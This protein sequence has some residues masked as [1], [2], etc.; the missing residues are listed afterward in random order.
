MS[1]LRATV[2]LLSAGAI[3]GAGYYYGSERTRRNLEV[4]KLVGVHYTQMGEYQTLKEKLDAALDVPGAVLD[5][6]KEDIATVRGHMQTYLDNID[7][8]NST[9][10]LHDT[11][12]K[13]I[14]KLIT[15]LNQAKKA[16]NK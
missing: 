3:F 1:F 8:E 9:K 7:F 2:N 6:L 13:E 4:N 14:N 12:S 10:K 11:A 5:T 16:F 15:K